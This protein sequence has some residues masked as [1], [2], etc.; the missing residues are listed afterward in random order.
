M[1]AVSFMTDGATLAVGSIRGKIY[2]YD[3]RVT[4]SP[5]KVVSAHKKSVR[6][7]KFQNG[8]TQIRV[9]RLFLL[10]LGLY[11]CNTDTLLNPSELRWNAVL[12][13]YI[14]GA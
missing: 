13:F 12:P 10:V 7:L 2:V 8:P 14:E 6:C 4:S 3:L 11:L 9:G 1:T 5:L